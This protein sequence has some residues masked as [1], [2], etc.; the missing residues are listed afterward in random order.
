MGKSGVAKPHSGIKVQGEERR[1]PEPGEALSGAQVFY[2]GQ[3]SM[4]RWSR[5]LTHTQGV[6]STPRTAR[7][8]ILD[9]Y[10]QWL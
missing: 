8:R 10:S 1:A 5:W 7:I 3:A 6:F 4:A 2:T 9:Q